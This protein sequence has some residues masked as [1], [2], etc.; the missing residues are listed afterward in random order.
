MAQKSRIITW[1]CPCTLQDFEEGGCVFCT[2]RFS[3]IRGII[4]SWSFLTTTLSTVRWT[5]PRD[6]EQSEYTFKYFYLFLFQIFLR[7]PAWG[8]KSRWHTFSGFG[9]TSFSYNA[10]AA[11]PHCKFGS[12]PCNHVCKCYVG[13]YAVESSRS[14]FI[15]IFSFSCLG[16]IIL[17]HVY[18]VYCDTQLLVFRFS[19]LRNS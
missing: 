12:N 9:P 17:L 6:F 19:F 2:V 1:Q 16:E 8:K 15:S 5:V 14:L 4:L 11:L 3:N 13:Q 7:A 18:I 10:R